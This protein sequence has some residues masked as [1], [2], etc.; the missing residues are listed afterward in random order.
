MRTENL[1]QFVMGEQLAEIRAAL[2]I[3]TFGASSDN[4]LAKTVDW[5]HKTELVWGPKNR[6]PWKIVVVLYLTKLGWVHRHSN[7]CLH[8][9]LGVV[10][11]A[12]SEV[13][14]YAENRRAKPLA[15]HSTP[16][17]PQNQRLFKEEAKKC[18]GFF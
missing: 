18:F 3:G 15:Q 2:S 17:P 7:D 6:G 10:P 12:E 8:G 4:A 1:R 11:P 9:F 13:T 5:L 16:G 14:F